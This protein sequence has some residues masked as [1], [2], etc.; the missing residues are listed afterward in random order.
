M[1]DSLAHG[2]VE[3]YRQIG[4]SLRTFGAIIST[5]FSSDSSREQKEEAVAGVGGPVAIGRVFVTLADYGVQ[6]RS[7][8]ILTAM[9]SLS[10]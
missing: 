7:L 9:I 8:I 4:F 1:F 2:M 10:L 5:S 3:V 6:I